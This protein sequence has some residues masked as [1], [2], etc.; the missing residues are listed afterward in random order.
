MATRREVIV[1][2]AGIAAGAALADLPATAE[3]EQSVVDDALGSPE[4]T[5]YCYTLNVHGG[6]HDALQAALGHYQQLCEV[7]VAHGHS[8][9]FSS[10][11]LVMSNLL[12][13][14]SAANAEA[15]EEFCAAWSGHGQKP[16][17]SEA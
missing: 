2:A 12:S 6:D 3:S 9:P 5:Q 13:E 15:V 4:M 1:G 8:R 17:T 11:R 16:R 10:N 14:T 7:M